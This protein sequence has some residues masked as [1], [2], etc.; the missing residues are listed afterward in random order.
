MKKA[1][2]NI[3]EAAVYLGVSASTV[4]RWMRD[5][6]L[7]VLKLQLGGRMLFKKDRLDKWMDEQMG[8]EEMQEYQTY[9]N[10][11]VLRP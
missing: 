6:G 10:L 3:D 8:E 11:K 5:N 7:P 4:R 9:G 1:T 2:M